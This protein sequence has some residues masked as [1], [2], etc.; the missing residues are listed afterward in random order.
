MVATCDAMF[1]DMAA[2]NEDNVKYTGS[3][4]PADSNGGTTGAYTGY[5]NPAFIHV[6]STDNLMDGQTKRGSFVTIDG[7]FTDPVKKGPEDDKKDEKE[8]EPSVPPVPFLSLFRF[9]TGLDI[10]LMII[11]SICACITGLAWPAMNVVF[12]DMT[13]LFSTPSNTSTPFPNVV[14]NQSS[15]LGPG[16]LDE[17]FDEKMLNFVY[18]ELK[19]FFVTMLMGDDGTSRAIDPTGVPP[20][21]MAEM[22]RKMDIV[23]LRYAYIGCVVLVSSSIQVACWTTACERQIHKMRKKFLHSILRQ[24]MAWFDSHESGSLTSRL[25]DDM[26][27]VKEGLGDKMSF[28]IFGFA[29]FIGGFSVGF[30]KAW[31]LTLVMLSVVPFL[32]IAGAF[33]AKVISSASTMEQEK[34]VKAGAIAEEVLSSIRTVTAF[35]GQKREVKRYDRELEASEK[36]GI[37]K[38]FVMG[39]G[40]GLVFM[41]LY[42]TYALAFW[43]GSTLLLKGEREV[44]EIFT[45]IFSVVIG[46]FSIGIAS[47]HLA[48]IATAKGAAATV[49]E[50]IDSVPNIDAYS[51]SGLKPQQCHGKIEFRNVKFRYPTRPDVQVLSGVDVSVNP[52]ETI[53][54]VGN[55]GCGKSTLLALLQRFYDPEEGQVLLDGVDIKDLNVHWLRSKIGVV[56]QMPVL[57]GFTIADN[58]ALGRQVGQEEVEQAARAANIHSFIITLPEGYNTTVGERGSQLSGGQR[59]RIAIARALVTNPTILLL[60]EATSALDAESE[61]VVQVAI[62]KACQ[63]RATIAIAHRLST[64]QNANTIYVMDKGQVVEQGTH[65]ELLS[66]KAMYHELVTLQRLHRT[67][68]QT[69]KRRDSQRSLKE[70]LSESKAKVHRQKS[71]KK[72]KKETEKDSLEEKMR[73]LKE[74]QAE[75]PTFFRIL[76]ENTPEVKWIVVGTCGSILLGCGMPAFSL[77]YSQ[78]FEEFQ[79]TGDAL[80]AAATFWACMFLVLGAGMGL[81]HFLQTS[82]FGSSGDKLTHRLRLRTFRNI[83]RQDMAYFDEERHATGKLT[84]RLATDAPMIKGATG[85]RL[86]I[87]VNSLVAA[88]CAIT[89]AVVFGWKLGLVIIGTGP[90]LV[91]AGA[92]SMKFHTGDQNKDTREAER[93]GNTASEAI[94]NI[95][96]VQ[97]LSQEAFFYQTFE[98]YAE[99]PHRL[100]LRRN[101]IYAV[102]YAFSQAIIF[103]LYAGAFRF[104]FYLV[105]NG[106]MEFADVFRVF[107]GIAFVAMTFGQ[108]SAFLPDYS[109]A[110]IS[111]GLI[112]KMMNQIPAIDVFDPSGQ[113]LNMQGDI[114]FRNVSFTYPSRPDVPILKSLSFHVRPG[115]T[116]AIVGASGCGKSTV[117]ALLE[118]FYDPSEGQILVD[119]VDIKTLNLEHFRSRMSIVAQEPILFNTTI[120]ENILYALPEDSAVPDETIYGAAGVANIHAF[121]QNLPDR[122]DTG[123]GEKGVQLSGGER[124]RVSIARAVVGDPKI[125]LLD[126]ATSALDS[127]S[128]KGVQMALQAAS[129]GRTCIVIAHRLSTIKEADVILVMDKGQIMEHGTHE[130][131]LKKDGAYAQLTRGQQLR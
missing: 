22:T 53:A 63:N 61:H 104:G 31:D 49:F 44:G 51:E 32:A 77:L 7:T 88:T 100:N 27:R 58:I 25:S 76:R 35:G 89:I 64:I 1:T 122:Y 90:I 71:V 109:K 29:Q 3:K 47:P 23:V 108:V 97:S 4:L 30:Y 98:K 21:F 87:M 33:I 118:R 114:E 34:Y 70:E 20:D 83:L 125:L 117:V 124:Q 129:A 95:Q 43:Y 93:A 11:G 59:Q 37:K 45:V 50:V 8:K 42:A 36:L 131:L 17:A 82:M 127:T 57:F 112:L 65:E 72:N 2:S 28:A 110:R 14:N 10:A 107:F 103:F 67:D 9:A 74:E 26:E 99:F 6:P 46:A 105:S 126:E 41:I 120:K 56:G 79:Q 113:T 102:T 96:T 62:D 101:K 80:K 13:N 55:S 92:L 123:V 115:Q 48:V 94:E 130:E 16:K 128:E 81:G 19:T 73:E 5:D 12:G 121:V 75:A 85:I 111:A 39:T 15:N 78:M 84:T 86:G 18:G 38:A 54:L 60:D 66:H 116:L 69:S 91:A 119:G 52:N 40:M 68:A 24:E 106:D